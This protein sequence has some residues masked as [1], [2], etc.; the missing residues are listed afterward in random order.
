MITRLIIFVCL[1][2]KPFEQFMDKLVAH[3]LI[4]KDCSKIDSEKQN[5][6]LAEKASQEIKMIGSGEMKIKTYKM[7]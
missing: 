5:R 6:I 2:V 7:R 3:Y 4:E 1:K